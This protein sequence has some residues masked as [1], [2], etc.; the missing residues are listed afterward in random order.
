MIIE[1]HII[2]SVPAS[3]I[4]ADRQG[5]PKTI[6]Y[7]G[8]KRA[9]LSSQSQKR[10]VR[11]FTHEHGFLEPSE[12]G[13]RSRL[14]AQKVQQCLRDDHGLEDEAAH[15]LVIKALAAIG[16]KLN[17]IGQN[18]Y[19]LFHSHRELTGFTEAI[20]KHEGELQKVQL[21]HGEEKDG[22][23]KQKR[24]FSK[25]AQQ[26][27][28]APFTQ[29]RA[30]EISLYGRHLADLPEGTV[31]GQVQVMHAQ[32][33]HAVID[34]MDFFSAVDDYEPGVQGSAGMLGEIGISAPTYYR[35]A[36]INVD[37]LALEVNNREAALLAVKA[38]I[39][40]FVMALPSGGRNAYSAQTSSSFVLLQRIEKGEALN[41][42]PAFERPLITPPNR[43][44]SETAV[45]TLEDYLERTERAF[46]L[47][48][49]RK[50]V[51]LNLTP[52]PV[53]T[54]TVVGDL[55]E[56]ISVILA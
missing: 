55:D 30:L 5:R 40:G 36:A 34:E 8:F 14:F 19:L 53:R 51:C 16:M 21:E 9:R 20:V 1:I 38:F 31:D 28:L 37:Q 3:R 13:Y 46:P 45:A 44:M 43:S 11:M 23:K 49:N 4:N 18:E 41:L 27:L 39:T 48:R 50:R 22:K 54:A 12:W 15:V 6:V 35:M 24:K 17:E 42:T 56:A 32:S 7:G 29:V 10:A 26:S 33:V 47:L 52:H 25:E 2:Q